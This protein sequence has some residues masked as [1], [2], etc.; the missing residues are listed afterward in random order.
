[1][2][3]VEKCRQLELIGSLAPMSITAA[4]AQRSPTSEELRFELARLQTCANDLG[5]TKRRLF[6]CFPRIAIVTASITVCWASLAFA[7]HSVVSL[8]ADAFCLSLALGQAGLVAHDAAHNQFSRSRV[9]NRLLARYH[10]EVLLGISYQWWV[11]KHNRHHRNPNVIG[12]DPD[13]EISWL[14][15]S[16]HIKPD[17]YWLR[18]WVLTHQR[19]SFIFLMMAEALHVR[20]VSATFILKRCRQG[21]TSEVISTTASLVFFVA[22]PIYTLGIARGLLF[23]AAAHAFLGIYLG[24]LF[25]PNH[26]GQ[27]LSNLNDTPGILKQITASRNIRVP[28]GF[29]WLFGGL[30]RQIEHHLFPTVL[31]RNL[32][33]LTREVEIS[34]ARLGIQ[35]CEMGLVSAV[36]K[37]LRHVDCNAQT[38]H[39]PI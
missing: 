39:A 34:C 16:G 7:R 20:W 8:V 32:S 25:L 28:G 14:N 37:V 26:I 2:Q 22:Y 5:L 27:S 1:M 35:Y 4:S 21:L 17:R 36:R 6:T 15:V 9:V 12:L 10:W 24:I 38:A 31:S 19:Q 23:F 13:L 29:G 33:A 11:Q 30:H 3:F 18:R